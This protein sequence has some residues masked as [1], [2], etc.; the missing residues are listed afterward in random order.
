MGF[1]TRTAMDALMKTTHPEIN[2]RQ[3]WNLHPHRKPC[4]T[5]KD[6]CPY[7]E[8]IFS[9]PNLVKDWDPCTDCGLC[10]SACRSGCIAPSPEQVQRDTAAADSDSD[11][12]WIG[13][14]RSARKN[15]VVRSCICALSWE[16]LAYLALNK[17]IVLDLTP[18][19][20]CEND[21]CAEQLRKELTRLVDFF[22]QP[23]FEA[24]FSLAY[25]EKEYPYHV[26][27]LTRREMLEQVS[28]GSK[29]GTKKLLQM[30]PGLRSE[31]DSGVDFRLLLHQ[32]T[33]QLK[34]AMETPLQ[35]GYYMPKFTDNCFGCGRCEKACRA[36]ALKFE[37]MPNGQTRMVLTPWKCSEC[38]VCMN[39][40]SNKG[41]D[42]M[43]LYQLTTLGPVVLHKCT[44]TLCKQCGKPIAPDSAEGLCSVCRIK[45]RTQKRQEEA[46]LRAE[47]LKAERAAK[48]AEDAAKAAE[49]TVEPAAEAA[50]QAQNE[51]AIKGAREE[52]IQAAYE[53]WQKAQAGVTIAEKSY[54]RVKNLY[55]Q[56]VMPAQ[57]LD[58]VTA[59]RDAA[60]AT[61]KAAKAQYTMA[62]NGAEREDKMAAEALV[63][64]AKG[65][66]AE[67]ESY[68][69]ETY[70]IAPAAGEVSEIFPKVGELVGT[71]API[72]NIAELNDMWVTFNV[73]E[74]LLKN[75]TMG[76]EFEAVVPALDNK[77]VRLKV[78][79]LK[80]LG[81]YAAWKATK[82]TGQFDLKTFEVKASPMEKVENLRPGMSVIINK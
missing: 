70:L 28:H 76:A 34:A 77:T 5:C 7:G 65:A 23:M 35:Y 33:K 38:G 20:Q 71:G 24:R 46:R 19:G 82:T 78:Y 63:N 79:Y 64:R 9:R 54:K 3:C 81:T 12:I 74:D 8:E 17:K 61:E 66:V 41:F 37:E 72:M 44:K 15:T 2:R 69:K 30:L 18:C 59:Q 51:K 55:E 67:V 6:I 68:I 27:E 4:T 45:A 80:D 50:A 53:M 31:E 48:A 26:Q 47:Q 43:K 32:R 1:F 21:L 75:L 22:G 10:V 13:C 62:K 36:N 73:R 49:N 14:E 56:G 42:G 40:C 39:V 57:K 60:I 52:Q 11:T 58:E 25:E 16:A 29:S